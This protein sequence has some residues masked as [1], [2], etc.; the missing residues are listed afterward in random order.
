PRGGGTTC[1]FRQMQARCATLL[2]RAERVFP[3]LH[4]PR[5]PAPRRVTA[6]RTTRH[7]RGRLPNPFVLLRTYANETA[8]L[9][10]TGQPTIG[11]WSDSSCA[12]RFTLEV[13]PV[14]LPRVGNNPLTFAMS[15]VNARNSER[16]SFPFVP[17]L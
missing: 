2:A 13:P 5:K 3:H 1:Y 12:L 11:R 9:P 8:T 7:V 16:S 14:T 10:C 6:L 4:R 15:R 17:T